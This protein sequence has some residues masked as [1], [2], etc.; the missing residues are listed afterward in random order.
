MKG[1]RYLTFFSGT[2]HS[3]RQAD[4]WKKQG[5]WGKENPSL[6]LTLQ[7]SFQLNSLSYVMLGVTVQGALSAGQHCPCQTRA[8]RLSITRST[9][10]VN[11]QQLLPSLLSIPT[12][13]IPILAL[14]R[15]WLLIPHLFHYN[16]PLPCKVIQFWRRSP[17]SSKEREKILDSWYILHPFEAS[18]FTEICY[19]QPTHSYC[20]FRIQPAFLLQNNT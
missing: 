20:S 13:A 16:F 15:G 7:Q 8:Q 19:F 17:F 10:N 4:L 9:K 6:E 12:Q 1:L 18:Y 3:F 11:F 14:Q 5:K 2:R